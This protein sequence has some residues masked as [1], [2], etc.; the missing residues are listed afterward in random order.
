MTE[1]YYKKIFFSLTISILFYWGCGSEEKAE[2]VVPPR[3]VKYGTVSYPNGRTVQNFSGIARSNKESQLSFKVAGTLNRV[4]VEIG[5]RVRSGQLI[6]SL[7]ATDYKVSYEQAIAQL[8]QAETQL[9]SAE[10]QLLT[11]K[12]SYQRIELLYENQSLPLSEYEQARST[13]ETA[14][15]Q[16]TSAEAQV[17]AANQQVNAAKNQLDYCRLTSPFTGII[18]SVTVEENELVNAGTPIAI[19]NA[20]GKTEVSVGIPE[21]FITKVQLKDKVKIRFTAIP[22]RSFDGTIKE[23]GFNSNSTTTYPVTVSLD[24]SSNEIRPGMAAEVTFDFLTIN[25]SKKPSTLV[26]PIQAVAETPEGTFVFALEKSG[27]NHKALKKN[28]EVGELLA[29][30]FELKSGLQAGDTV[31]TAGIKTLFDGMEVTLF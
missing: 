15:A 12:S 21:S 10:T 9:V 23:V 28:V 27:K 25:K 24:N 11:S 30:G 16:F 4:P 8:R 1:L 3:P 31:A 17:A 6:A 19:L 29:E 13:Y 18:S 7:D 26:V 14:Q 2:G 22:G 20:E 5:D